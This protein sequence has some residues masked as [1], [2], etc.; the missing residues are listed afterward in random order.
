MSNPYE[1]VEMPGSEDLRIIAISKSVGRHPD[2]HA[3]SRTP[4]WMISINDGKEI[5]CSTVDSSSPYKTYAELYGFHI[6]VSREVSSDIGNQLFTSAMIK[7][8]D[9]IA[10]IPNGGYIAELENI[11]NSGKPVKKITIQGIGWFSNALKPFTTIIFLDSYILA[12]TH[13]LDRAFIRFRVKDKTHTFYVYDQ[14]GTSSGQSIC[15]VKLGDNTS[16]L[17]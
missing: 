17:S 14:K 7:H 10:L 6:D 3:G 15:T 16:E 12:I 4:W 9:C 2:N 8:D 1:L 13:N 11:M 5:L